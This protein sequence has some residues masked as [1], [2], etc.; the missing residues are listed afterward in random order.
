MDNQRRIVSEKTRAKEH[1]REMS[2]QKCSDV[3]K[4]RSD[5]RI[6]MS[7]VWQRGRPRAS[8]VNGE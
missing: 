2:N 4:M 6:M 1:I 5:N 8:E 7:V 3:L